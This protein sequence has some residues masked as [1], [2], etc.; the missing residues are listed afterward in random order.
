MGDRFSNL[1][2]DSAITRGIEDESG[3]MPRDEAYKIIQEV[4][5]KFRGEPFDIP[6]DDYERFR[7]AAEDYLV[8]VEKLEETSPGSKEEDRMAELAE[9]ILAKAPKEK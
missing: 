9:N 2:A 7:K 4:N 8:A 1:R 5:K 6:T 3:I